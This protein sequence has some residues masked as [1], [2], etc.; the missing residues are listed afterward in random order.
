[1]TTFFAYSSFSFIVLT[2]WTCFEVR[3]STAENPRRRR[4]YKDAQFTAIQNYS[5]RNVIIDFKFVKNSIGCVQACLEHPGC[6]S[7]NFN[8]QGN[9][10]H[11]CELCNQTLYSTKDENKITKA[12][13]TYLW[14]QYPSICSESPCQNGGNCSY[15]YDDK[16]GVVLDYR[17][18]CHP[19]TS[20]RHCENGPFRSCQDI[21]NNTGDHEL[22]DGVYSLLL[23]STAV[24]VM[25]HM[26][27]IPG[28]SKKGWMP[29]M[30]TDP[31]E[32]TFAYHSS[33]WSNK[34]A[35]NVSA[36]KTGF[37]NYETKLPTYWTVPF[38][39]LCVG[40]RVGESTKFTTIP[41][42]ATSLYD[43]V[44]DGIERRFTIGRKAWKSLIPGASLQ[45]D[46]ELEGFNL[47]A[48]RG[49]MLRLG[50]IAD[51][52]DSSSPC[53]GGPDSF[54]GFAMEKFPAASFQHGNMCHHKSRHCDTNTLEY[55]PAFGY[56]LVR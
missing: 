40:F 15:V 2:L 43:V 28:C 45:R 6:I 46:C 55:I 22:E 49:R 18:S 34:V 53:T 30:K 16:L 21:I 32:D 4:F 44:A 7:V 48:P 14:P 39:E 26:K 52:I 1:M 27:N 23:D 3:G 25:C 17:C 33:Y 38:K 42:Q 56:I 29:V 13:Y 5:L 10:N 54:L 24:E 41:Y 31:H 51:H 9:P 37:D 50:I 11:L 20:G 47:K 35:Y 36:G 8:T 19:Y 12:R